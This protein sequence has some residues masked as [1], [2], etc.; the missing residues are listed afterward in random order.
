[1][2]ALT[3]PRDVPI[4]VIS[5]G[6]QTQEQITAHRILTEGSLGGRHVIATR[7]RHWV[8]F[9]EPDLV[10]GIILELVEL[11]RRP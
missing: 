11:T 4:V 8:Q 2:G 1:M 5:S 3:P 9:D 10:I 6:D 7:S